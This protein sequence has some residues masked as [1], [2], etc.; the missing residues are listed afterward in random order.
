MA[1]FGRESWCCKGISHE[2]GA[3]NIQYTPHHIQWRATEASRMKTH[4][5]VV[6]E[7]HKKLKLANCEAYVDS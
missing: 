6:E 5:T 2:R 7:A 3:E 1:G 4:R